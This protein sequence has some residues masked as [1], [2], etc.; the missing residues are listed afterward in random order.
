MLRTHLVAAPILVLL[1]AP[2]AAQKPHEG[3][4]RNVEL[5]N[6][7]AAPETKIEACSAFIEAGRRD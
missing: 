7:S 2:A 3:Q 5:C 4:F 6:S 1:L